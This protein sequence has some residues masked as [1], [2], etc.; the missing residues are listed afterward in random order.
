MS[1]CDQLMTGRPPQ[2][3]TDAGPRC[4]CGHPGHGGRCPCGCRRYVAA[5]SH[6]DEFRGGPLPAAFVVLCSVGLLTVLIVVLV[7]IVV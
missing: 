3:G 4:V 2:P 1:D 5:G 7:V 6:P